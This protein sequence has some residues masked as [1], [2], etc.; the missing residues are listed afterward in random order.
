MSAESKH[1]V[2]LYYMHINISYINK[3]KIYI[4]V[5]NNEQH[6]PLMVINRHK[7]Q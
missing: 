5:C 4:N 7:L 6:M 3:I 1:R 2:Q